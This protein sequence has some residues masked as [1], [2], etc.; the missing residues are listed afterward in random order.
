MRKETNR[1]AAG[2]AHFPVALRLFVRDAGARTVESR[3]TNGC[4]PFRFVL[5]VGLFSSA[6]VGS[7]PTVPPSFSHRSSIFF[8]RR[9][10]AIG[11]GMFASPVRNIS[12]LHLLVRWAFYTDG[13]VSSAAI[14]PL[15]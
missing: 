7:A 10:L 13:T 4:L 12:N 5:P 15:I 8:C 14:L 1:A 6:L 9:F 3:E 2:T 11:S